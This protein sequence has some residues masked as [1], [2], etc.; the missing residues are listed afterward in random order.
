MPRVDID[1][2]DFV[3]SFEVLIKHSNILQET[4]KNV[5]IRSSKYP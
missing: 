5:T 2:D 1:L 4:F 3:P